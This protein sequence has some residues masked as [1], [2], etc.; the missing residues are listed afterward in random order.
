VDELAPPGGLSL[1]GRAGGHFP[2]GMAEKL[3]NSG[4]LMI[5]SE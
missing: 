2:L 3:Y 4:F 5:F 1:T